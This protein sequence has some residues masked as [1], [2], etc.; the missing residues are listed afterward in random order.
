MLVDTPISEFDE[1]DAIFAYCAGCGQVVEVD[2][3]DDG[4][5]GSCDDVFEVETVDGHLVVHECCPRC[6]GRYD[7]DECLCEPS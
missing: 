6:E 3:L 1:L 7:M 4:Y 5:C 2:D